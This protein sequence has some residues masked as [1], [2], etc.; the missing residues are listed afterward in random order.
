MDDYT[1]YRNNKKYNVVSDEDKNR[2]RMIDNIIHG[3]DFDDEK[4]YRILAIF[5][6]ASE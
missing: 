6:T 1:F 5:R 3:D 2:I 4:P